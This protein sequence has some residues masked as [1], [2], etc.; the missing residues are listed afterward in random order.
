M[1][2]SVERTKS[3]SHWRSAHQHLRVGEEIKDIILGF[4]KNQRFSSIA[5]K[6]CYSSE[7]FCDFL[8][9]EDKM[10][11]M[12]NSTSAVPYGWEYYYGYLDPPIVDQ[13]KLKYNKCRRFCIHWFVEAKSLLYAHDAFFPSLLDSIVIIFWLVLGAFVGLL[14]FGLNFM[15]RNVRR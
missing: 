3:F 4:R 8:S 7:E 5:L 14:F 6:D 2:Q 13:S 12:E 9:S 15:S 10:S 11:L 1:L